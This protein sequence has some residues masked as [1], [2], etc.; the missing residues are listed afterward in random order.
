VAAAAAA[1]GVADGKCD[2]YS[3]S[4]AGVCTLH[5]LFENRVP[6]EERG[7]QLHRR[8]VKEVRCVTS[9][10]H[11]R[12]CIAFATLPSFSRLPNSKHGHGRA[13]T[14]RVQFCPLKPV[15][16]ILQGQPSC[17]TKNHQR[18]TPASQTHHALP[19]SFSPSLKPIAKTHLSNCGS[20]LRRPSRSICAQSAQVF[21][22]QRARQR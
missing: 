14:T 20:R 3:V 10:C 2:R 13:A 6:E 8:F 1:A 5:E 15:P 11:P 4:E 17:T 16:Q 21:G 18:H 22:S 12:G 9:V 19:R 7:T